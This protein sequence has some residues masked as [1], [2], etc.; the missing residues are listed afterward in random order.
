MDIAILQYIEDLFG[1]LI[2]YQ[3]LHPKVYEIPFNSTN[4]FHLSIHETSDG[5]RI[6]MKGAPELIIQRCSSIFINDKYIEMTEYWVQRCNKYLTEMTKKGQCVI[7]YCDFI[8]DRFEFPKNYEF[9]IN[10]L[11]VPNFPIK[12]T[13]RFLGLISMFDPLRPNTREAVKKCKTA[14]IRV[15]MITGILLPILN[16]LITI[17][18]IN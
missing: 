13:M 15:I 10:E 7:G 1:N 2:D 9:H 11:G 17:F 5:Y 18:I 12:N 6:V 4:K 16:K 8:L 14:G 3:A